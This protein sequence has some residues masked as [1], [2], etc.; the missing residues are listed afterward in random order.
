MIATYVVVSWLHMWVACAKAFTHSQ[1]HTYVA[2][3]HDVDLRHVLPA[4]G[5]AEALPKTRRRRF[6]GP[7]RPLK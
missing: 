2:Y 1:R 4:A 7:N 5:L 3:A 6:L